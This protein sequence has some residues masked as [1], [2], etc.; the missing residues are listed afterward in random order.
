MMADG[1]SDLGSAPQNRAGAGTHAVPHRGL[2][3]DLLSDGI[4][5]RLDRDGVLG[6]PAGVP[7]APGRRSP[8]RLRRAAPTVPAVNGVSVAVDRGE[9]IAVV[10]GVGIRQSQSPPARSWACPHRPGGSPP[11]RSGSPD[12]ELVG[13]SDR[14]WR[15]IA[16]RISMVFRIDAMLE[17]DHE[18][19]SPDHESIRPAPV[20]TG[21]GR[22]RAVELL[23]AV[24]ICRSGASTKLP[25]PAPAACASA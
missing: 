6:R 3:E 2:A 11:G 17:P 25:A 21:H 15:G 16:S 22:E 10:G 18:D 5:N 8:R 12:R 7:A 19:R 9:T 1:K 13:L 20:W 24:R 23:D 4:R 14:E